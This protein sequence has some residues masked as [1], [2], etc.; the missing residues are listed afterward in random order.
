MDVPSPR[1]ALSTSLGNQMET[2]ATKDDD[3]SIGHSLVE[4]GYTPF[5]EVLCKTKTPHVSVSRLI[6]AKA[7]WF[8]LSVL[9]RAHT[10]RELLTRP[11]LSS[12]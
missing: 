2:Y 7:I 5:L 12:A 1:T 6:M 4:G 10:V 3:G 9:L 11:T 8:Y